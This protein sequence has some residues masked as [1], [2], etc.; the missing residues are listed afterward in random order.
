MDANNANTV[1]Q[2]DVS[3]SVDDTAPVPAQTTVNKPNLHGFLKG[4]LV[5]TL[6][7]DDDFCGKTVACFKS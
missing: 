2:E 1:A 5:D 3:G 7:Q 6:E 4:I